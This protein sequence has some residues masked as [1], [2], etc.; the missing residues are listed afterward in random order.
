[1]GLG[2]ELVLPDHSLFLTSTQLNSNIIILK[3]NIR[4]GNLQ[5]E[6]TNLEKKEF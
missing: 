1:M 5:K 6:V 3:I 2:S 4:V